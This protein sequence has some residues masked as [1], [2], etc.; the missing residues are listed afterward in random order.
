MKNLLIMSVIALAMGACSSADKNTQEDSATSV[1]QTENNN[2][3]GE[4]HKAE[5]VADTKSEGSESRVVCT[6]DK[7]ER[8]IDVRKSEA[9]GCDLFYTK[10]ADEKSVASSGFGTQY[11]EEV[12]DRIQS[13][14]TKAGFSCQ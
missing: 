2:D 9:G 11:C 1:E 12:R 14:L 8:I 10:F 3:D 5:P 6:L 7:D 4:G 13:N